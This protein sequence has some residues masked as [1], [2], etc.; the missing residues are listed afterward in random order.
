M[1]QNENKTEKRP[2]IKDIARESGYS[3]TAVSFAFND[4]SR[5]SKKAR[6]MIISTAN[7]LGYIPDPMARNF[8]LRRH[9]SIGFLLP[10]IINYSM[11]NPYTLQVIQGIG[12]VCQKYGYTLTLIPPLNESIT[13]AV[14]SAA[15]DGLITMGMQVGMDIVK[16][17]KI[18][19]LP[20][21]TIDGAPS[22]GM[23]SVNIQ[24]EQAAYMI[25]KMVLEQGHRRIVVVCMSE[26]AFDSDEFEAS[27][28]KRRKRGYERA[29]NEFGLSLYDETNS[30]T[31]MVSECTLE[32][33]KHTGHLISKLKTNPTA[34]VTM[35]DIIAIGCILY[36]KEHGFLVPQDISV[37][38]FDNINEA[39]IISPALTTVDQPAGEKGYLAAEALF[40]MI[41]GDSLGSTHMEIPFNIITRESLCKV[42]E[43]T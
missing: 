20:F 25:M 3:K 18:R 14:R 40:R 23:P 35:S 24:D 15:V 42:K 2:T 10:Q 11:R 22:E 13:D 12:S 31:Q 41:N 43:E 30:I 21:V 32:D 36:F 7:R 33:G 38:G 17:M 6:D 9:L 27:V 8:S 1:E 29:F 34:V 28:P 26:D 16:I 4:P 39:Q 37:V 5:I 19:K